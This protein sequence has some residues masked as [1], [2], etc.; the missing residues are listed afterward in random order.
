MKKII[1]LLLILA[2]LLSLAACSSEGLETEEEILPTT[3]DKGIVKIEINTGE[4]LL[5]KD[6]LTWEKIDAI[7]VANASM[8]SDQLRQ[9]VLDFAKLSLSFIWQPSEEWYITVGRNYTFPVNTMYGG[10]PYVSSSS[11]NMYKWMC[12]LNEETGILDVKAVGNDI[13]RVLGNQCSAHA[14]SAFSRVSNSM[15]WGGTSDMVLKHGC[16][17]LGEYTYDTSIENWDNIATV[18]I[19]KQNGQQVMYRSYAKL[20]PADGLSNSDIKNAGHVIMNKE[21][22]VETAAD[23][24]IDGYKSYIIYYEQSSGFKSAVHAN[25]S[26]QTQA[27][28]DRKFTFHE[29]FNEGYLPWTVAEFIGRD[30]VEKATAS[31]DLTAASVTPTELAKIKITSNYA[32]SVFEIHIKDESGKVVKEIEKPFDGFPLQRLEATPYGRFNINE[33][34]SFA[35]G[36]HTAE[37]YVRV[38]SG[39]L[40]QV[41]SGTLNNA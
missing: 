26:Y 11:G 22:H 27:G 37:V 10:I 18:D 40:L 39:E 29:L 16:I 30:P 38:N 20:L 6:P 33:I 3:T 7:P 5:V 36:K 34:S 31:G 12:Y 8:S 23:G 15:D 32:I 17:P 13:E 4:K 41:Y 19:C 28:I 14:F 2:T 9:I 24:S 1:S 25:T 35:D 21:V